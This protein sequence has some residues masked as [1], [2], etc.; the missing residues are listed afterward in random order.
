MKTER[1]TGS[2][3]KKYKEKRNW[4][5][6]KEAKPCVRKYLVNGEIKWTETA[7]ENNPK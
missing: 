4:T 3:R 6:E 1:E 2:A 7:K 5:R